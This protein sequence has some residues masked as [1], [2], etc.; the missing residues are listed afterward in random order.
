MSP[1]YN[2]KDRKSEDNAT[3]LVATFLKQY[4]LGI[5]NLYTHTHW[6]NVRDGKRGTVDNLNTMKNSY[7]MCP[8]YILPHC[9]EFRKKVLGYLSDKPLKQ[10]YRVRKNWNDAKS[11]IG[12]F[13]SLDNAKKACKNGYIVFDCNGAVVFT[14]LKSVDVIV[15]EVIAG[16][17]GNG[18]ARK[19]KLTNAG[20]DYSTI[21][22]KVNK[23]QKNK[24]QKTCILKV[25]V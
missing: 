7:K 24:I 19:R 11:Q 25:K 18:S 5:N 22:K 17:W 1:A 9:A 14:T 3:K 16:K 15:K 20:Y 23:I 12:A 13:S 4:V 6:L 21:Q 8:L 10:L 2:E